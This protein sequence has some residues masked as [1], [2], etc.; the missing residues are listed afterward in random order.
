VVRSI[1]EIIQFL[2]TQPNE[3]WHPSCYPWTAIED[4]QP[5]KELITEAE[6]ELDIELPQ[7]YKS[8]IQFCGGGELVW[9]DN[10]IDFFD[11]EDVL[12]CNLDPTR[13]GEAIKYMPGMIFFGSDRG[14]RLYFFDPIN[15]MGRGCWATYIAYGLRTFEGSKYI[16]QDF[17]HFI[18]FMLS[19]KSISDLPDLEEEGWRTKPD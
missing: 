1:E 2:Q 3:V 15:Y 16:A 5:I 12:D 14:E 9:Q 13:W 10:L 4:S 11:M 8:F 18:E 17:T 6:Q 7:D 19:D